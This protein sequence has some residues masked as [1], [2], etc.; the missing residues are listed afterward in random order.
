MFIGASPAHTK[1]MNR[2]QACTFTV[3]QTITDL[4]DPGTLDL[5]ADLMISAQELLNE[6]VHLNALISNI[7]W[8]ELDQKAHPSSS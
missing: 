7:T 5:R 4:E 1:V 6:V 3:R 2:L 8:H